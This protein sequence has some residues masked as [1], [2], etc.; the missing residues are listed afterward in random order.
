MMGVYEICNLHD[1]KATAYVGS[2]MDIATRWKD[3]KNRLRRGVHGN[4]HLQRAFDKYGGGAF[5]WYVIEEVSDEAK[6]L[7]REQYWLG[8]YF[9]NPD[10]CYNIARDA[11]SP[12]RGRNHTEEAKR[13][14]SEAFKDVPK[15]AEHRRKLSEAGMG[16]VVSEET[17][18]KISETKNGVPNPLKGK[19]YPAFIHREAG[20]VIPAGV[21]LR[22][23]CQE[24]G[25]SSGNM[26]QVVYGQ[27]NHHKGWILASNME[28]Q[29]WEVQ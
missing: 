13:K 5:E 8:R 16:H 11:L 15:S 18:R 10:T 12:M 26:W 29:I 27:R 14:V 7:E 17:R 21:D 2:S 1:G 28:E 3:H 9:E 6:L 23:L 4:E 25:L 20:N 22:R 24:H 19:P